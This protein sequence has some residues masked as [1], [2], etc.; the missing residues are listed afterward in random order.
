MLKRFEGFKKRAAVVGG[1][2]LV[3]L[4]GSSAF[5]FETGLADADTSVSAIITIGVGIVTAIVLFTIG[6]RVANR[7]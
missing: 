3:A 4:S 1:T 5:A 2:A 6:K 7:I